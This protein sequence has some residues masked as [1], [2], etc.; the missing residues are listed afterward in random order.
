MTIRV[1]L[2]PHTC[3]SRPSRN[4]SWLRGMAN[5]EYQPRSSA[6]LLTSQ[7]A[8]QSQFMFPLSVEYPSFIADSGFVLK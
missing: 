7:T 6:E 1:T 8:F 3:W 4:R 2:N 5:S